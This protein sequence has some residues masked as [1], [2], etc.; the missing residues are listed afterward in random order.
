LRIINIEEL[1]MSTTD[2]TEER[3]VIRFNSPGLKHDV[4]LKVFDIDFHVHSVIL[5]LYSG[6]FRK[7]L[8]SPEKKIPA[9]ADFAYEWVT[10][11]DEDGSW[12]LICAESKVGFLLL[13]L[14]HLANSIPKYYGMWPNKP[15]KRQL[16]PNQQFDLLVLGRWQHLIRQILQYDFSYG[17]VC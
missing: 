12:H 15:T 7:F 5:K 3:K 11:I 17:S 8:D 14:V 16:L 1:T 13:V 10:Q 6:F 4:R 9:S 2:N